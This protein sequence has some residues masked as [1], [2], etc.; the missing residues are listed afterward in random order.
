M[1]FGVQLNKGKTI[2]RLVSA[3]GEMLLTF[4]TSKVQPDISK[5]SVV[6]RSNEVIVIKDFYL[7]CI[8]L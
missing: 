1:G 8:K 4:K 5:S 3:R 6:D 7:L 2:T